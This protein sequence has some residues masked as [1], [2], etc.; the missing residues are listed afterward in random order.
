MSGTI[1]NHNPSTLGGGLPGGQP[2]GGLLG[3]GGG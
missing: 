2:R 3:G 1:A